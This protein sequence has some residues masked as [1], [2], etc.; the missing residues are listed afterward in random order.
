STIPMLLTVDRMRDEGFDVEVIEFQSPETM[1]LAMQSGDIHLGSTN[2]GTVFSAIDAGFDGVAFMGSAAAD[3]LM[4][5]RTGINE[6]AD[7]DGRAVAIQ[8]TVSTTG[9]L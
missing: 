5:A 6:C 7:L 1:S 3:F 2:A 9:A 4:V 8:S